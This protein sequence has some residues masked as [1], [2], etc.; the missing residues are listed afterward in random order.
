M[1]ALHLHP[2]K[3]WTMMLTSF[4]KQLTNTGL[5]TPFSPVQQVHFLGSFLG[6]PLINSVAESEDAA[7]VPSHLC[8]S[9]FI[10][11]AALQFES[12]GAYVVSETN[13]I[14]GLQG[15]F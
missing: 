7:Q 6:F 11:T 1:H 3:V 5:I 10:A 13:S 14:F 4:P 9:I 12:S 2:L 8:N 15:S